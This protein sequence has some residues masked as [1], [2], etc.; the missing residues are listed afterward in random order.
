MFTSRTP[1][2][3]TSRYVRY[4]TIQQP[5]T[6][7]TTVPVS[8]DVTDISS[9]S[10]KKPQA[11][12]NTEPV[13]NANAP[14]LSDSAQFETIGT[15]A[16]TLSLRIPPSV[17]VNVKKGSIMSVYS[18]SNSNAPSHT[19]TDNYLKSSWKFVQPL[20]R[21]LL[22][23]E[24][25]SYQKVI[26]TVPLQLLVSAYT[27]SESLRSSTGT[28][29]FVNLS[30]DGTFD[31]VLFNPNSLHCYSGNS[32]NVE[33]KSLPRDL[34]NGFKGRGYTWLNGRGMASVVGKGS[35][36]NVTLGAEEE[37]RIDRRNI[38]A[39]TVKDIAELSNGG[40]S[41]EKWDVSDGVFHKKTTKTPISND[42]L[43]LKEQ[44]T[45]TKARPTNNIYIDTMINYTKAFFSHTLNFA[46]QGRSLFMD[47]V[48]DTGNY[49]VV[50]GPRTVLIETGAGFDNFVVNSS[51]MFGNATKGTVE[52]LEQYVKDEE[53]FTKPVPNKGDDLGVVRIENGKAKYENLDN[54]DKEVKRIEGLMKK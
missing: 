4:I 16:S 42:S 43:V 30:L 32:L 45:T 37:I 33:V 46:N 25:A 29:S 31:W 3:I 20:R 26:G 48:M 41:A 53:E 51:K 11:A 24:T 52:E 7:V 27:G 38:F 18:F 17:P 9:K 15:P 21:L 19:S 50:R 39:V 10:D 44:T 2:S 22:S 54:F 35:V 49:V 1:A 14:G 40:V 8:L 6:T 34:Q 12:Y 36:F 28:K 5:S 23:G 13:I 47:Y